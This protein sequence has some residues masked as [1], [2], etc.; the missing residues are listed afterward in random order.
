MQLEQTLGM[1]QPMQMQRTQERQ[2]TYF[3]VGDLESLSASALYGG[4][5]GGNFKWSKDGLFIPIKGLDIPLHD[6]YKKDSDGNLSGGHSTINLPNS[7][8]VYMPHGL[9]KPLIR[10]G[11]G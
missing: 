1:Y 2:T 10:S 9:G 11:S 4:D 8:K 6:T 3:V 5:K 7:W